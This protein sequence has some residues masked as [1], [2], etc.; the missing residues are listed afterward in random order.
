MVSLK[1]TKIMLLDVINQKTNA[2]SCNV[3]FEENS[4][5][6]ETEY[7]T[8]C[9]FR[10]CIKCI[11]KAGDLNKKC[12]SCRTETNDKYDIIYD[13]LSKFVEQ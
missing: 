13:L 5:W 7:C 9:N 8:I 3:C 10:T 12:F 6:N 4:I 1:K 11:L 2:Y